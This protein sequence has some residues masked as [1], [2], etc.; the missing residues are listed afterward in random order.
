MDAVGVL[1]C[2]AVVAIAT[3][4]ETFFN[5][6]S[7]V[8]LLPSS[9]AVSTV[10]FYLFLYERDT[11]IDV[12]TGLFN[13]ASY[14][15]DCSKTNKNITG[16]IQLD[17]NGLKYINDNYGHLEGD[18]AIKCI[19]QAIINNSTR[20]MYAYRLGGDEF[21]VLAINES[22]ENILRFVS[23]FKEEIKN[24]KYHC[25]IGYSCRGKDADSVNKMLKQSEQ[26]MY[27]DKEDFYK[28]SG[29]ERRRSSLESK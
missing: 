3:I 18:E 16:V 21:V 9:I 28:T 22:E 27:K 13:R 20:K 29:I 8:Y 6:D 26:R 7:G 10:F 25:S 4:I 17:M 5:A 12:L 24:S 23:A 1:V 11:K 14:F 19:A 15:D 2:S